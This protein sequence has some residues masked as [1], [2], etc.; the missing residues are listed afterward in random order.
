MMST[1]TPQLDDPDDVPDEPR[2]APD[3]NETFMLT[4]RELD[5]K[6]DV[7]IG[8]WFITAVDDDSITVPAGSGDFRVGFFD[9]DEAVQ[10]LTFQTDREI[11]LKAISLVVV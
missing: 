11:L 10:K 3:L 9:Y 2:L 1:R 6:S 5:G 8:W 4:V 7:K